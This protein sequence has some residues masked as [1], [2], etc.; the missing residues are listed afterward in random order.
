MWHALLVR[1]S[2]ALRAQAA[3]MTLREML[4][5]QRVSMEGVGM[6][7]ALKTSNIV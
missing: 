7:S 2:P 6:G 1:W 5:T 4:R 3:V